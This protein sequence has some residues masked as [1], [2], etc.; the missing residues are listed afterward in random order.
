MAVTL[1]NINI[2]TITGITE[3]ENPIIATSPIGY[4]ANQL[5][6]NL[7]GI[8]RQFEVSGVWSDAANEYATK[9]KL[10]QNIITAG[11]PVWLDA[12]DWAPN[13]IIFGRVSNLNVS[14]LEGEYNIYKFSFLVTEVFPWGYIFVQDDGAGDFRIYDL[15]KLVQTRHINPVIS[16]C[17]YSKGANISFSIYVKNIG[18]ASGQVT[19]EMMVPD[20]ITTGSISTNVATT[21]AQGT[22]GTSGFSASPG[23]KNRITLKR[24]LGSGVEEQ[25]NI[26][27]TLGTSKTSFIDG[28][29]DDIVP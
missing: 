18:A 28:S 22:V 14:L 6:Q 27:I 1:N 29:Y 3:I 15:S 7:K 21:K 5:V 19:L 16:N 25:W 24:T 10:V 23:T 17:N 20:D 2:E 26:T 4:H 9:K 8:S 12:Q 11:I 13:Q